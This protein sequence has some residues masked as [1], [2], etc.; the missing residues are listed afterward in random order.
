MLL[1]YGVDGCPSVHHTVP[2]IMV[3][4]IFTNELQAKATYPSAEIRPYEIGW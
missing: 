4:A 1:Q 2:K 3:K